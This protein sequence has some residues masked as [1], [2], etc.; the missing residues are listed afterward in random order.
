MNNMNPT[1]LI[2]GKAEIPWNAILIVLT[3]LAWFF[4]SYS[5]Y[6]ARV[7]NRIGLWLFL[8]LSVSLSYFFCRL[9]YW[10][11]NQSQFENFSQALKSTN[12]ATF[13]LLGLL[14]GIALSAVMIRL[15]QMN[16]NLPVFFDTLCAPT[17]FATG[18]FYLTC[19]FNTSCR[20]KHAIHNPAFMH[21]PIAIKSVDSLGN[22][23]YRFATFL[24]GSILM[25]V[26][27]I[28][29]L[30]FYFKNAKKKGATC[31]FFL[32][33]YSAVQFVLESTRYDAG[34]FPFNGFVSI[35]QIFSA[36]CILGSLI[37]YSIIS[38]GKTG[39]RAVYPVLWVA[40]LAAIGATGYLE[41]LVQR[42]GDKA[43]IIYL[44]MS[45]SCLCMAVIPLLVYE[46]GKKHK[47]K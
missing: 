9:F 1:A 6:G 45:L 43:G 23:E 4:F 22:V 34:Y 26:I 33:F 2:I 24:A 47:A 10:Y 28:A 46:S 25:C 40:W 11:S 39:F 44:G 8:P 31:A 30:V 42:H 32:L 7:K 27:G 19:L 16:K 18:F 29:T 38:I 3:I 17:A 12:P 36:V 21:F 15:L 20:G 41:Y 37:F 5:L 35:I 13:S 14:P